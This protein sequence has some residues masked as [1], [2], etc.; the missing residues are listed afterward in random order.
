MNPAPMQEHAV[1]LASVP[2]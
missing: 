1:V 2:S